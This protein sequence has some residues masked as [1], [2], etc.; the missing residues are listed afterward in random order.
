MFY[1]IINTN[2]NGKD[3]FNLNYYNCYQLQT[4]IETKIKHPR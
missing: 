3:F 1:Y 2:E 4:K